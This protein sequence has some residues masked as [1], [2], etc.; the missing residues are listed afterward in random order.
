MKSGT[1]PTEGRVE[2]FDGGR[3]ELQRVEQHVADAGKVDADLIRTKQIG[4]GNRHVLASCRSQLN[5]DLAFARMNWF[6]D[7]EERRGAQ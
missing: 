7:E 4:G 5:L 2:E 3:F 1:A 6:G